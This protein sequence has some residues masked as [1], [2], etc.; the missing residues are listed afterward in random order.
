ML[1]TKKPT[2]PGKKLSAKKINSTKHCNLTDLENKVATLIPKDDEQRITAQEIS[3]IIGI[4]VRS[5]YDTVYRLRV[6][7]VPVVSDRKQ[8][9]AGLYI[10]LTEHA[11]REGMV[12]LRREYSEIE[13][14]L[15][16]IAEADL[17]EWSKV[18]KYEPTAV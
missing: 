1:K 12:A 13:K 7:G 17:N 18:V 11:R 6:K 10:P 16:G 2:I 5:V 4:S 3:G 14:A 8:A 15:N 9:T